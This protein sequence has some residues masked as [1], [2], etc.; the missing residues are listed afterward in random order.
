MPSQKTIKIEMIIFDVNQTMFSLSEIEK[1]FKEKKLNKTLVDFWFNSVLKEGFSYSLSGKFIDFKTI[2]SNELKKIFLKK[3]KKIKMQSI[4]YIMD[5]FSELKVHKDIFNALKVLNR[6]KIKV[7]TLT[8]G[9]IMNTNLL[10]KKNKI[11]NLVDK[12]FSVDQFNIW[13]PHKDV[14]LN[15]CKIMKIK[16]DNSLM[17]AAHGWDING[18]KLA[19]LKTAFISRYEKN[20]SNFYLSPDFFGKDSC[21]IINQLRF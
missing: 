19:G 5:G 11:E 18:A 12:C 21:D 10:L 2:G 9:S 8:N 4:N 6:K 13:K 20:L 17:I 15:T 16:P 3:N 1:R 7:I 14:Y